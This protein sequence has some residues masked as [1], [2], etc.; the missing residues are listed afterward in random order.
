[1]LRGRFAL[2]AN[3]KRIRDDL[4]ISQKGLAKNAGISWRSIQNAEKCQSGMDAD[5]LVALS[6]YL[7]IPVDSLVRE[8]AHIPPKSPT[9]EALTAII[10]DQE[11]RLKEAQSVVTPASIPSDLLSALATLNDQEM[12]DVAAFVQRRLKARANTPQISREPKKA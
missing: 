4:D 12:A 1:M 6:D 7:G 9:V 2:A 8:G 3:L 5:S 11:R 10:Q